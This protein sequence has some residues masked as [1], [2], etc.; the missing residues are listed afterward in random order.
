MNSPFDDADL[1]DAVFGDFNFDRDFYVELARDARGPVLEVACGTGRIL[2]PCQLAGVDIDG[3]DLYPSML[4][5]LRRKASALGLAPSLYTADMRAFALPR[6]Y[7]LVFIAFNGFVHNLTTED[8]LMT[9]KT[10]RSHLL[11]GGALVFNVFYPA[12]DIINGKEG[13]PVLEL[14]TKHPV[15]GT[16]LRVYDTRRLNRVEQIQYSRMEIQELDGAGNVAVSHH[17]E[18]SMRWTFKPEMELLLR[19]AGFA[20][21][22]IFGGFDRRPLARETDLM[23]VYASNA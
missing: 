17:S 10:C 6:R 2:I 1:Y 8:Q 15:T 4:A 13:F 3:L 23:L 5:V 21:W 11:P 19:A 16:T 14:E 18:T 22:Q 20:R 7:A 12:L 9:L